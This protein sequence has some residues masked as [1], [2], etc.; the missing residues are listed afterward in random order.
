MVFKFAHH[1]SWPDA[2]T[3]LNKTL[4]VPCWHLAFLL[5]EHKGVAKATLS[6]VLYNL[7]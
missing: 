5:S 4:C 6:S 1:P 3:C 7:I 2:D